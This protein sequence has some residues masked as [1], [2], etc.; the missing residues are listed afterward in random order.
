M[1]S[2]LREKLALGFMFMAMKTDYDTFVKMCDVVVF[3]EHIETLEDIRDA[4]R[5]EQEHDYYYNHESED[6]DTDSNTTRNTTKLH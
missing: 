4:M 6:Y 2:W 1:I 3:A 5:L